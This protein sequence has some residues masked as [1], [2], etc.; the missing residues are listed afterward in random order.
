M[1]TTRTM[2][3]Y[4]ARLS[5]VVLFCVTGGIDALAVDAECAKTVVA[6]TNVDD[7]LFHIAL[8]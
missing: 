7:N 5:S 8:I 4:S 1:K 2:Y 3:D 6:R